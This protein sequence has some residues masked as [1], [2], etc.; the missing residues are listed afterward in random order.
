ML[1]TAGITDP[2]PQ[3][4]YILVRET[5]L[6]FR[7]LPRRSSVKRGWETCCKRQ[8]KPGA[9]R[10][11]K[12]QR[13]YMTESNEPHRR[14]LAPAL[15]AKRHIQNLWPRRRV[16][17]KLYLR[18]DQDVQEGEP[19]VNISWSA[20]KNDSLNAW[21]GGESYSLWPKHLLILRVHQ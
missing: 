13:Q 14:E 19:D 3:P 8:G 17:H 6:S 11:R 15:T 4:V 2:T 21:R 9:V 20:G 16:H 10:W 18:L 12:R 1:F 5:L 7:A